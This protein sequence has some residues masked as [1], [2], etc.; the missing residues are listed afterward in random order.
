M[1]VPVQ[2]ELVSLIY[3]CYVRSLQCLYKGGSG[4]GVEEPRPSS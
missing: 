3:F 2:D 4:G 1:V